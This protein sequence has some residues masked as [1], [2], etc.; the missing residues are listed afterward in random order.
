MARCKSAVQGVK[1][2][3]VQVWEG[4]FL[5]CLSSMM[6]WVPTEGKITLDERL[7]TSPLGIFQQ[8]ESGLAAGRAQTKLRF[9]WSKWGQTILYINCKSGIGC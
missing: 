4:K 5:Q 8:F 2:A 3:P 1:R 9:W 6:L 7:N